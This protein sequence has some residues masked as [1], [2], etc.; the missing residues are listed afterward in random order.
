MYVCVCV[1]CGATRTLLLLWIVN[2]TF[3][4]SLYRRKSGWNRGNTMKS[5]MGAKKWE[6]M[7]CSI[8]CVCERESSTGGG[9][10]NQV[11]IAT[12]SEYSP[13]ARAC[14]CCCCSGGMCRLFRLFLICDNLWRTQQ[15]FIFQ[16]FCCYILAIWCPPDHPSH[17][18]VALF[19]SS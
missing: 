6:A 9:W 16:F 2:N 3:L 12:E 8:R 4:L 13:G 14:V 19:F 5:E 10:K 1:L 11:F 7:S 18:I 17:H 15:Y